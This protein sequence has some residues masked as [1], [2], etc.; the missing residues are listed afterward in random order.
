MHVD[1]ICQQLR[2]CMLICYVNNYIRNVH[3]INVICQQLHTYVH[4]DVVCQQLRTCML[5]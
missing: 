5:M 3:V 1:M 4:V 2:T